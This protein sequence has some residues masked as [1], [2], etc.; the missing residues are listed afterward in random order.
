MKSRF[1]LILV[2][3]VVIFGGILF[4][5]KKD[6]SAPTDSNGQPIQASN[7]VRGAGTTGVVLVEYGDFQCPACATYF[8]AVEE[9][10][11][12]YGDKITF[13]FRNFP[14]RQ[15]HP[16]A[17]LAHRSV[18]AA[19]N[20]GKF[21]EMYSSLYSGQDAWSS[22][23]DP[24]SVFRSYAEA[25]KLDMTKFDNDVKSQAVNDI[26]NADIA[27]GQKLDISGTPTFILDGKKI[28]SPQSAEAFNKL[29]D[30]AIAAKQAAN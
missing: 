9:V 5:S 4:L 24:T 16:N 7:H 1:S 2:A 6:A 11:K 14:L 23:Q 13:Q 8:T 21:W 22:L 12:K 10:T 20:Q 15:I 30:E 19:A 3:C 27:E 17:M 28:E 26:I 25:L 29:I 18:E